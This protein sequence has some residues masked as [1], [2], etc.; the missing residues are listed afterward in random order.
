MHQKGRSPTGR[1]GKVFS[2]GPLY[3]KGPFVIILLMFALIPHALMMSADTVEA[4]TPEDGTILI[5]ADA[6]FT[7]KNGVIG[8]KGSVRDPYIITFDEII[9]TSGPAIQIQTTNVHFIIRDS[10][11]RGIGDNVTMGILLFDAQMAVIQNVTFRDLTHGLSASMSGAVRVQDS[12]VMGCEVGIELVTCPGAYLTDLVVE[13]CAKGILVQDS[14]SIDLRGIY[15]R[16]CDHA[17]IQVLQSPSATISKVTA[18]DCEVGIEVSDSPEAELRS[19]VAKDN[20]YVDIALHRVNDLTM[21]LCSMG[22]RGLRVSQTEGATIGRTNTVNG[23][24]LRYHVRVAGIT[25]D[26][27]AGQVILKGCDQVT[28][29]NLEMEGVGYPLQLTNCQGCRVTNVTATGAI[30]ALDVEGGCDLKVSSCTLD[31]TGHGDVE[32]ATV[33]V[34][35][36]LGMT[37]Q[38]STVTGTMDVGINVHGTK[39]LIIRN[40]TVSDLPRT[41]ICIGKCPGTPGGTPET[42]V[43]I[44][45]ATISDNGWAGVVARPDTLVV[46]DTIFSGN[47]GPGLLCE[48]AT[49]VEVTGSRFYDNRW[50]MVLD[51]CGHALVEGVSI[52][53]ATSGMDLCR[54]AFSVERLHL[55]NL[56]TGITVDNCPS[57]SI[58]EAY[59]SDVG[60]TGILVHA[61]RDIQVS[62]CEIDGPFTG[63]LLTESIECLV[64]RTYIEEAVNGLVL[65]GAWNITVSSCTI[66]NCD[67]WGIIAQEGGNYTLYHNNLLYNNQDLQGEGRPA[68]QARDSTGNGSWDDREEGNFWSDYL[69]RYPQASSTGRTWDVPYSLAGGVNS[70]DRYP[71]SLMVDHDPPVANAGPDLVVNQGD[72]LLLDGRRSTD[73][74]GITAYLWEAIM[75]GRPVALEGPT[76]SFSTACSGIFEVVLTV[77]DAWGNERWDILMVKVLDT[78]APEVELPEL[79]VADVGEPFRLS[80]YRICDPSGIQE[81]VWIIDP[82]GLG[83]E[84]H[85][86]WVE[87]QVDAVGTYDLELRVSDCR[88]NWALVVTSLHVVDRRAPAADAGPDMLAD[89]GTLVLLDASGSTDNVAIAGYEWI[90]GSGLERCTLEGRQVSVCAEYAGTVK[91]WLFVTDE[92]GN[93]GI[94][95]MTI[96][97]RDTMPPNACAGPDRSITPGTVVTLF[98]AGSTDNVG[99]VSWVWVLAMDDRTVTLWGP[100]ISWKFDDP[101]TCTATLTVVDSAGNE[102]TVTST[103]NVIGPEVME[104]PKNEPI[105]EVWPTGP[106]VSA[107][108]D[109]VITTGDPVRLK[110]TVTEGPGTGLTF[111]W[112]YRD[113][114]TLHTLDGPTHEISFSRPG[115]YQVWLYA[116]DDEGHTSVDDL[117]VTVMA[118]EVPVEKAEKSLPWLQVYG[119]IVLETLLVVAIIGLFRS[120]SRRP[121]A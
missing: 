91:V 30:I 40:V 111:G 98:G 18:L 77:R 35:H 49:T 74:V 86:R 16:R 47:A 56:T 46:N 96:T 81:C 93:T 50:G 44:D 63:I 78:Q 114:G 75:N 7:E 105:L 112:A 33:K 97:V 118:R 109:V 110:A 102:D 26:G 83:M 61:S 12:R 29:S 20:S 45:G 68:S 48:G 13:D 67:G 43:T 104:E 116:T 27:S 100:K 85:G 119:W 62:N 6:D 1:A 80:P 23:A 53:G 5:L 107:G 99:I 54:S 89:Q 94:D 57:G 73:N 34:G 10:I 71:L 66:T 79:I 37:L 60:T 38:D 106:G 65:D 59:I 108:D 39:D 92:A 117:V 21:S 58:R 52:D 55:S 51:G 90:V 31:S 22:P 87:A 41:A 69:D 115:T 88:G 84:L 17:G 3:P 76:P 11:V 9:T 19:C 15:C 28:I 82:D 121:R 103:I 8:G 24:P 25:I 95:R 101:G 72:T 4:F 32:A 2:S 36:H 70:S 42:S 120:F 14:E 64:Q 113:G